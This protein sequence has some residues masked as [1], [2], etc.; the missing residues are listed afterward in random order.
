M[1]DLLLLL[2]PAGTLLFGGAFLLF[3][4]LVVPPER[5]QFFPYLASAFVFLSFVLLVVDVQKFLVGGTPLPSSELLVR[6]AVFF[7]GF[8][9]F[10]QGIF[11][12]GAFF[13]LLLTPG[14]RAEVTGEYAE[15]EGER[16]ALLLLATFGAM[17]MASSYDLLVLFVGMEIL[18][19][20]AIVLVAL[21]RRRVASQE[22]AFKYVV[23][24][25]IAS[26]IFL[27][28]LSFL[29]GVAGA[30]DVPQLLQRFAEMPWDIYP[31]A[32]L[33]VVLVFAGLTFKVSSVPLYLWAPDVYEGAPTSATAFLAV[34]SK[35]AGFALFLRLFYPLFLGLPGMWNGFSQ[36]VSGLAAWVS[37]LTMFVAN[38][39]ALRQTN[40]KRLLAYSSIAHSGYILVP[41]AA[42]SPLALE[43]MLFYL[44]AYLFMNLGAFAVADVVSRERGDE[45]L[46]ALRGLYRR[47]PLLAAFMTLFVLSLAGIPLTAGFTGKLYLFLGAMW[48]G[49]WALAVAMAA[50]SLI[51]YVYYFRILRMIFMREGE[52]EASVAL[53]WPQATVLVLTA[54][55]TLLGGV[56]PES[57]FQALTWFFG[58]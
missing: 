33:G 11:L 42:S 52:G 1:N 15:L 31:L 2:A 32:V 4:L 5:R 39:V 27:Y 49:Q 53:P 10:F 13:S 51:A 29:V 34:V 7:D 45:T 44:L 50:A 36:L 37:V 8:S 20:A 35:A 16:S 19:V 57:F 47:S 3:L 17:L 12:F 22:A 54:I 9:A 26:G 23:F 18:T 28:G 56:W 25:G 48:G 30:T 6:R 46:D 21:R 55:G 14:R 40:L 24:S 58:A 41:F 38:L 43:Q